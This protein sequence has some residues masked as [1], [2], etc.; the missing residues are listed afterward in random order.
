MCVKKSFYFLLHSFTICQILLHVLIVTSPVLYFSS[1]RRFPH[2]YLPKWFVHQYISERLR[3]SPWN[4]SLCNWHVQSRPISFLCYIV[5][6]AVKTMYHL[7]HEIGHTRPKTCNKDK[8]QLAEKTLC[9][10][11]FQ[12][13]F[14]SFDYFKFRKAAAYV[15]FITNFQI[16]GTLP[17]VP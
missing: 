4:W 6:V 2:F 17:S 5:S 3:Q 1:S 7:F 11:L 15:P 9:S 13:K 14:I 10:Q 16:Y 12:K 8:K